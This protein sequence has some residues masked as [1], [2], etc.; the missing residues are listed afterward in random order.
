MRTKY[1]LGQNVFW[2]DPSSEEVKK[3]CIEGIL[4]SGKIA[5]NAEGGGM[6]ATDEEILYRIAGAAYPERMLYSSETVLRMR[7]RE[8]FK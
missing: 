2:F 5:K 8:I 1:D 6:A 4:V 3:G 7:Y